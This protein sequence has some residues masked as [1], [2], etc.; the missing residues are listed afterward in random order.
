MLLWEAVL[1]DYAALKQSPMTRWALA[2]EPFLPYTL[3]ISE[4]A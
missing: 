4:S 3:P 1:M 2:G